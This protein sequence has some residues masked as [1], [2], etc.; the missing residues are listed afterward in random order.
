EALG[1]RSTQLDAAAEAYERANAHH[2]RLVDELQTADQTVADA[3]R[4]VADAED[5]LTKRVVGAYKRPTATAALAEAVLTAPDAATALHRAALVE[6]AAVAGVDLLDD[7]RHAAEL[8]VDGVR[9]HS[10]V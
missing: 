6:K 8:T 5:V 10:V 2:L 1:I 3:R 9:Q 4:D 7:V